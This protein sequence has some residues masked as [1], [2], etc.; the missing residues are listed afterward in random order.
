MH[1][2]KACT[3]FSKLYK[4]LKSEG[5]VAASLVDDGIVEDPAD[6]SG[7]RLEIDDLRCKHGLLV[8]EES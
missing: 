1:E 6:V 4:A 5:W 7:T 2:K 3:P 8:P